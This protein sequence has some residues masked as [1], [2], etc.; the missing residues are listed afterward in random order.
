M[1]GNI[2]QSK[3]PLA[4][5]LLVHL[6]TVCCLNDGQSHWGTGA[7]KADLNDRFC[8]TAVDV[9]AST[10][11]GGPVIPQDKTQPGLCFRAPVQQQEPR[12]RSAQD[13]VASKAVRQKVSI[14]FI[15]IYNASPC[16]ALT[17]NVKNFKQA[18]QADQQFTKRRRSNNWFL[19][20][21]T[22]PAVRPRSASTA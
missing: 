8:C 10:R 5:D 21:N 1:T 6:L 7:F 19:L 13:E 11:C 22:S 4:L 20:V 16:G 14:G 18:P 9:F 2:K 17:K 15:L 12:G 3:W